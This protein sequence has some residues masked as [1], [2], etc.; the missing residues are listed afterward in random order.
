M[1]GHLVLANQLSIRTVGD[2]ASHA[3]NRCSRRTTRAGSVLIARD[4]T[5]R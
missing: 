5:G 3:G 2:D 1:H 4:F